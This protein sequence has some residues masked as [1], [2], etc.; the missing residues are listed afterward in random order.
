MIDT[1]ASRATTQSV[2]K[3]LREE[4][5]R[6]DAMADTI[7]PILRHLLA[8]RDGSVFGDEII[9]RV[10]GMA[11]NIAEQLLGALAHA[12]GEQ[13][14]TERGE[15]QVAQLVAANVENPA[16]LGH[17]HA[18][19]LE[20]QLTEKLQSRI[21]LDPVL[22]PLLQALISSDEEETSALAMK[23]LASQARFCQAQ[24][25]MK[26]PLAEL[27]GDLLHNALV[28]M[29]TLA[30]TEQEAD[31]RA[32]DAEAA[33][34]A[35]YDEASARLGLIARL[36]TTMGSGAIA[37]LSVSHAGPAIFLSAL[38][39]GSGQDRDKAILSTSE[40]QIARLSLALRSAGVKPAG[41]EEQLLTLHPQI[42]LPEGFARISA[43]RAAA[44][45]A[46][47]GGIP[48]G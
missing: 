7:V 25:R 33:I 43:D 29:R 10:R 45:L 37:A 30:G 23:L 19:A 17:L 9:A 38:A 15:E 21:S 44:L 18:I 34:R 14:R 28:A 32:E 20:W 11:R 47:G 46:V 36:V 2:E 35:G 40:A 5:A 26:L 42:A 31:K 1:A 48:E 39:I 6:G 41:V 13:E 8:N 27:P 24:R 22:S 3:L 16:F 4:L 12:G